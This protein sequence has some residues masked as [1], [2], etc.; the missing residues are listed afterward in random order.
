MWAG[1]PFK[2]EYPLMDAHPL[3]LTLG[4]PTLFENLRLEAPLFALESFLFLIYSR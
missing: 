2:D 3:D 4:K 1:V